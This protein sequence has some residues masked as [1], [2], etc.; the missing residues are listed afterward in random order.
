MQFVRPEFLYTFFALLIPIVVHLFQ[1]RR[2]KKQEFTNLA[3]LETIKLQSRKSSIIKKWLILCTRLLALSCIILAFAQPYFS[4]Q[5]VKGTTPE[6]VIYL[7]NS[8]SMKALGAQG[9]LLERSVQELLTHLEPSAEIDVFTNTKTYRNRTVKSIQNELLDIDYTAYQLDLKTMLSKGKMMFSKSSLNPKFFIVISDFQ[10][11]KKPLTELKK[12]PNYQLFFVQQKPINIENNYIK[13]VEISPQSNEYK[14]SIKANSNTSLQDKLTLSFYN[15]QK[16]LGKTT[17]EKSNDYKTTMVVPKHNLSKAKLVLEDNG[18]NFDDT[19]YFNIPSE[20]QINVLT[21]G[22]NPN[23]YLPRIFTADEFSYSFQNIAS[24]GYSAIQKQD[25]IILDALDRIPNALQSSLSSFLKS[26][27]KLIVIPSE[28]AELSSYNGLF[29]SEVILK[30]ALVSSEKRITNINFD[31][32]IYQN[33][34]EKRIKNFQFPKVKT[35]FSLAI[36]P[37]RLLS[38]QND[39]AFLAQYDNIFVFSSNISS[40]DSNFINSPLVVPTFYSIGTSSFKIPKTQYTIGDEHIIESK[41]SLNKD[42]V[43]RLSKDDLSFIPLQRKNNAKLQIIT[44]ELPTKA[45]HYALHHNNDTLQYLS[46]N[47]RRNE[48][49]LNYIN[50]ETIA[51]NIAQES[52]ENSLAIIKS[53]TNTKSIWKWFVTFAIIFLALEMLILKFFK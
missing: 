37:N 41:Y 34:F 7:D 36:T 6:I 32:P 42:E 27:G 3:F 38:Y 25:L 30:K 18:L 40:N 31:H 28:N 50:L 10:Q 26:D 35:Y 8:F 44:R 33:I 11:T 9:I 19:F 4:N 22:K 23:T 2:F 46:Y 5:T 12:D 15:N 1:L 29:D 21:I 48:S 24:M 13:Y 39:E 16:L 51:P 20:K 17:L 14:L 52:I 43:L 45:G 49:V 47:F 53:S